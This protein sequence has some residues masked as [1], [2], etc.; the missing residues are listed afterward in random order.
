MRVSGHPILSAGSAGVKVAD[1]WSKRVG[2]WQMAVLTAAGT[3]GAAAQA[4]AALFYW[5]DS[6]PGYYRPAPSAQPR[7]Q[8]NT[9]KN[10]AA[11][12]DAVQKETGAKPQGP[13]VI[14]ISI[15]RQKVRVYDANGLFAE[16]PVS[17]GMKGHSTPMGVF[18]IIQKHKFHHSNIYSGAPMPYMQRITWSGVAMHAGV[19]PGYPASHGCIRMPMAFAV[20]MW[21]WTKMGARVV[22]TPGD[23]TPASF[24]HPLLVAQKV[25]PQPVVADEPKN[26]LLKND[27]LKNDLPK[28]D[29]PAV[30]SDK[31]ADAGSAIRSENSVTSL[32]LR[33]T[34]GHASPLRE[35]TRT[36]DASSPMPAN[37]AATMSDATGGR[38]SS[39]E[40]AS[41]EAKPEA[42]KSESRPDAEST[43]A[44]SADTASSDDKSA[45]A[46]RADA[47]S[48]QTGSVEKA[49][50]PTAADAA[51][52]ETASDSAK[53]QETAEDKPAEAKVEAAKPEVTKTTETKAPDKPAEAIAD[54][55]A[56]PDAKK[57]TARLPGIDKAAAAKAEPKRTGQIAVFVSRKDSKLYVRQNFAPLFDVPVT[58]APSDRPLGTHVFTAEADKND[59]NLLRW[60][61]VSLPVTARNAARN[62][63]DDDRRA[64]R[65]KIAGGAAAEARPLPAPD[66]PAEALDRITIPQDAM[67]RIT[68]ALTTGSSIIVSDQGINQGETG[69]GTDFIVSLR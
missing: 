55:P 67:A 39:S 53:V 38:P 20:K 40:A 45:E 22:V 42:P 21:N 34:V 4:D 23:M 32:E 16:S 69:E 1:Q 46:S 48:D 47:I 30:K 51:K 13:L 31:G 66:S 17:T 60:S 61:V 19:L 9:R 36:A 49:D 27:L 50:A 54:A 56:A 43:P 15:D 11:K 25:T 26:D 5:Q 59:P 7:R 57:D 52:A 65:R 3:L 37:T 62:D 68:E 24:S 6:D 63:D 2:F 64:R 12:S 18:S 35:Q 14:A 29:M 44:N 8:R 28:A 41:A 58:I 10:S 33:S